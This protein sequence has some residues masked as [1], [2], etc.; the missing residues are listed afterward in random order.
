[1]GNDKL[2]KIEKVLSLIFIILGIFVIIGII[3][4][5]RLGKDNDQGRTEVSPTEEQSDYDWEAGLSDHTLWLPDNCGQY[6]QMPDFRLVDEK[7]E[8]Y[9]LSKFQGK[10]T[11]LVFWASWCEDCKK[12]MPHMEEYMNTAKILDDIQ[13]VFIN[14]TDGEKETKESASA[15]FKSLNLNAPLYYDIDLE[16]YDTL[17]MHNIP[18][19][20]FLDEKGTIITLSP[21]PIEQNSVFEAYIKKLV[22]GNSYPTEQFIREKLMD[23]EGAVHSK[24]A[25]NQAATYESDVLSESQGLF[26]Q[27][28]VLREDK[29]LFD[30][31]YGY[32]KN[33]LSLSKGLTAWIVQDGKVS[34]VNALL[35][36]LRIYQSLNK[37]QEI[38]GGYEQDITSLRNRLKQY[39][40]SKDMQY[41]DFYDSSTKDKASRLTLCYI[42]LQIMK[43]LAAD[44]TDFEQAYL[45]A[46]QL[47]KEG[48]ISDE[49]PL[50]YSWYNYDESVY[51]KD[52]INMAEEMVTILH[53]AEADMLPQNTLNWIK[54]QMAHDG[55][56]AR[57]TTDGEIVSGYD[58]DSTAVYALI[59]QLAQK[60]S[61]KELQR[62]ALKKMEKMRITDSALAYDGAFGMEDGSEI[63]SFDQLVPLLT[64]QKLERKE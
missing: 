23:E 12:Q 24:Y 14:K 16:A 40:M 51:E 21:K 45:A 62:Q 38:W 29:Q 32:V 50:Y 34:E 42:D 30:Q 35:D 2:K 9:S 6:E 52:E 48:Q 11:V 58:F 43:Q 33:K 49:F 31:L 26:M 1:M 18:T 3:L 10:K 20:Y 22:Y 37:A 27:Y 47:L 25:K 60:T 4:M 8:S 5:I 57:Y 56:K 41:V 55:I 64:Y 44:S 13:F 15:Y 36:D 19:T 17:G 46:E 39:G 28:A 63:Y 59:V 61:E 53:L 54:T 7:G